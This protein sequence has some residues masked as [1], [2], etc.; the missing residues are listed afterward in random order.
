M[1]QIGARSAGRTLRHVRSRINGAEILPDWGK[2]TDAGRREHGL[3]RVETVS[4]FLGQ[5][6][7]RHETPM[8]R[9]DVVGAEAILRTSCPWVREQFCGEVTGL[10]R[11]SEGTMIAQP[12]GGRMFAQGGGSGG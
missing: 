1:R 4:G 5:G 12:D 3:Q 9:G 6:L 11:R 10:D 8:E 2:P 7:H